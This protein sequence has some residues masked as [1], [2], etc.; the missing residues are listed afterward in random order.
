MAQHSRKSLDE[1]VRE[2]LSLAPEARAAFVREACASDQALYDTATREVIA[3]S[4][5][6]ADLHSGVGTDDP[7]ETAQL[8]GERIGPYQVLRQL[9]EGGMGAV[10]LAERVDGQFQQQVAIKLVRRGLLSKQVQNR[11]RI[12]RQI[13]ATLDHPNIAK[14]LDGGSTPDGVPY[15]VMEY[16]DG[17][18]IDAYCDR[19]SLSVEERLRLFSEVCSAVHSAHQN[20]IVHRDLKP[21]NILVTRNGSPKLLDFGIAKLLDERRLMQTLAVTQAD[22]RLMTPDHAS[23]EQVRGDPIT[24]SSD[25]YVLAI[26]LYELLT[27]LKPFARMTRLSDLEHAICEQAPPP[28]SAALVPSNTVPESQLLDIAA[29]RG[30]T[31]PKLRRQLRGDLDKII[32]MGLRKEPERRYSS[33]AQFAADVQRH[34]TG[35]PVIAQ[36]DAWTYRTIKFIRRHF[37]VVGM[38]VAFVLLLIGFT[39]MTYLQSIEIERERDIAAHQRS[40]AELQRARAEEASSF[41]TELFRL[42]DP[43]E[44]RGNEVR[45]RDVLD[46]GAARIRTEL[47]NQPELQATLMETI[48]RVYLNLGLTEQATPL[49]EQSLSTRRQLFGE[50]D[51]SIAQ[52][53]T[54]LA[55]VKRNQGDFDQALSLTQEA[56]R[57]STELHG[58]QSAESALQFQNL[59]ILHYANG[60]LTAAEPMLRK[61]LEIFT[62]LEGANTEKITQVLDTLGRIARARGQIVEAESLMQRAYD[63]QRDRSGVDHPLT[64]ERLHN[65]ATVLQAKGDHE[66]AEKH[67]RSVIEMSQRVLEPSHPT[68]ADALSNLAYTLESTGRLDEAERAYTE[69]AELNRRWRG[70]EHRSV[71]YGLASVGMLEMG[72]GR[73]VKAEGYLR[74]A[75]DVYGHSLKPSHPYV[76]AANT[77][78]GQVLLERDRPKAAEP[79]LEQAAEAWAAQYG[80]DSDEYLIAHSALGRAWVL[81]GKMQA[82]EDALKS[83]YA[84]LRARHGPEA[85]SAVKVQR[86]IEDMYARRGNPAGATQY[87]ASFP[88]NDR[89]DQ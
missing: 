45:V 68:H 25:V 79:Y 76:A 31:L 41:M 24:T 42:S 62:R 30:T 52:S 16:I 81:Q 3:S 65:L 20:L 11:L 59:G 7:I 69:A 50:S 72:R 47:K 88:M 10:Y 57:I 12:E 40:I 73:M 87:F 55:W 22:V 8:Q 70:P 58:E 32:L 46:R 39:I 74:Q 54:A 27:G 82:A 17:D 14:L 4:D 29:R 18:P 33:V 77:M 6:W 37:I 49:V 15:I 60:D 84:A 78:L 63:I 89:P 21:S 61:S 13:L 38:S 19:H 83:S 34:V 44:A 67:L 56:L 1:I 23:P 2:A 80:A 48:G 53:L 26:L 28:P 85:E 71:G 51:D 86:W 75:L 36:A 5:S 9:G 43:S 66:T 64:I 35:L